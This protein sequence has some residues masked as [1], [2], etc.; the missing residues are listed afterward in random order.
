MSEE[1]TLADVEAREQSITLD[2]MEELVLKHQDEG[3]HKVRTR[4]QIEIAQ[5]LRNITHSDIAD[6]L[7]EDENG[8]LRLHKLTDLP[9]SIT[10][11]IKKIKLRRD[12]VR[13]PRVYDSDG[14]V[15]ENYQDMSGEV[16]EIEFWDKISAADKLMRHYGGYETDNKQKG[17]A[18]ARSLDSLLASISDQGLPS[19][20]APVSSDEFEEAFP[21]YTEEEDSI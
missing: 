4:A 18:N 2:E 12:R 7:F 11:T 17:D 8:V 16:V 13:G 10:R 14:E 15:E 20:E 3:L 19:L 1:L 5:E 9:S 21:E 6:I